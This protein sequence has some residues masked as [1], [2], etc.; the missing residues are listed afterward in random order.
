MKPDWKDA[1]DWANYLACDDDGK[2][3]WYAM[4]PYYEGCAKQWITEGQYE[5]ANSYA[6]GNGTLEGKP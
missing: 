2:W 4:R 3:H 6:E 1:P 5:L